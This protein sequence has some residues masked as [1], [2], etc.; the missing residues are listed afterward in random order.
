MSYPWYEVVSGE[1]TLQQGDLFFDCPLVALP[2]T[3]VLLQATQLLT[4]PTGLNTTIVFAD[5]ILL[6]QSCDIPK[7]DMDRLLVCPHQDA[8]EI[9]SK[10]EQRD[11]IRKGRVLAYH[12]IEACE[13]DGYR[14]DQR[15]IDFRLATPL[16][17]LLWEQFSLFRKSHVR[18]LPPYREKM[19]QAFANYFMRIGLP[20]DPHDL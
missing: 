11:N 16:P 17:K 6:T 14:F 5:I 15:V 2:D 20:N 9:A 18:L 8:M 7:A 1:E 10:K 3:D 12:L 4:P 19:A 13:L